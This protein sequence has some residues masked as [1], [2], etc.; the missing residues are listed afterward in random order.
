[1]VPKSFVFANKGKLCVAVTKQNKAGTNPLQEVH[2]SYYYQHLS[3]LLTVPVS[4]SK[5]VDNYKWLPVTAVVTYDG[6]LL[7]YE[8]FEGDD[9]DVNVA[10]EN[11]AKNTDGPGSGNIGDTST[12]ATATTNATTR[13]KDLRDQ[14]WY[15]SDALIRLSLR[16]ANIQ[17]LLTLRLDAFV[18]KAT[19]VVAS[20]GPFSSNLPGAMPGKISVALLADS[21]D[22]ARKWLQVCSHPSADADLEPPAL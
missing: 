11:L 22:T 18:V 6:S 19:A 2:T 7:L 17:P 8:A 21:S 4:E 5:E 1:M 12:A 15:A 20:R 3:R 13:S 9:E 16:D 14:K 10:G